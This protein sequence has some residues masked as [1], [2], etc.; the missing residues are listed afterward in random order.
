[1]PFQFGVVM[2]TTLLQTTFPSHT[3]HANPS[4]T[5]STLAIIG[6]SFI[7]HSILISSYATRLFPCVY[8]SYLRTTPIQLILSNPTTIASGCP[9]HPFIHSLHSSHSALASPNSMC[10]SY[11]PA[12]EHDQPLSINTDIQSS[13]GLLP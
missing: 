1:M 2:I 8:R 13:K 11:I 7:Y 10:M 6:H 4:I 5:I 12:L 3:S 9:F